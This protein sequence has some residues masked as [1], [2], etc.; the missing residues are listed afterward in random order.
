MW[1]NVGKNKD[2]DT[3]PT[4]ASDPVIAS[5]TRLLLYRGKNQN[6]VTY[7]SNYEYK[8]NRKITDNIRWFYN[9]NH[10]AQLLIW[11]KKIL[12]NSIT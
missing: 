11:I 9:T 5:Q 10:N 7:A 1:V 3:T 8:F 2:S 12:I 6:P 4:Q